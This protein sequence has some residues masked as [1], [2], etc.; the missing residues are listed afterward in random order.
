M[1]ARVPYFEVSEEVLW[2]DVCVNGI[3]V[4]ELADPCIS[5]DGEDELCR[6]LSRCLVRRAVGALRF[7]RRFCV[8]VD[9]GRSVVV[10]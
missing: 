6:I 2:G 5:D 3:H 7:M 4:L 9:D 10:D 8:R 1:P